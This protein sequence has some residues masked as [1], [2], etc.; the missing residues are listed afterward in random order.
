MTEGVTPLQA[1][2]AAE[3]SA[4]EAEAELPI[5]ELL[6]RYRQAQADTQP[7]RDEAASGAAATQVRWGPWERSTAGQ[8]A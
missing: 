1:E 6:A 3:L 5:Q 8:P 7:G 4:L 2:T